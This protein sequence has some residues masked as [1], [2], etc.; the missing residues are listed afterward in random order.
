MENY[1]Q[2]KENRLTARHIYY[3]AVDYFVIEVRMIDLIVVAHDCLLCIF[4]FLL[5]KAPC[6]L[7]LTQFFGYH[8]IAVENLK[9]QMDFI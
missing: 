4:S 8:A 7:L 9:S 6:G 1:T 2:L 3:L 5:Y